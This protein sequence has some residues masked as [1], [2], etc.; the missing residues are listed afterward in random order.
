MTEVVNVLLV[1]VNLGIFGLSLNLY[2][3]MLKDRNMNRRSQS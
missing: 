1:I 3:E 2:T